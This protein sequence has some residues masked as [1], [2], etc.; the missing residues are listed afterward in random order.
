MKFLIHFLLALSLASCT[1][2]E[3]KVAVQA[4]SSFKQ[5]LLN[6]KAKAQSNPDQAIQ[7]I[8][9]TLSEYPEN[10]LSDDALFLLGQLLERKGNVEGA[11]KS[12]NR[13]LD[14]KYASPLDG[15]AILKLYDLYQKRNDTGK[16]LRVLNF[17]DR[18]ELVDSDSRLEIEKKRGPL[19]LETEDYIKYLE[20][21]ATSLKLS[22]DNSYKKTVFNKALA[23]MKIKILGTDNS[24]ILKNET[25][26]PFHPQAALH[27]AEYYFEKEERDKALAVL[28]ENS[29]ILLD[30]FY[31][32]QKIELIERAKA[33]ESANVNV[34]GVL[35]PLSG[36]YKS[37]GDKILKGLQFSLNIW[38]Q[39]NSDLPPIRL[40]ILDT[41][42]KPE[43]LELA[44]DEMIKKDRPV[45]FIGGLVGRTAEALI[46]KAEEFKTPA[47]ILSQKEGVAEGYKYSF[48][49][50]LPLPEYTN[51]ISKL[52]IE[53]LKFKKASVV[54]SEKLFS[55]MYAEA[56]IKSFTDMGG[57][58]VE[59]IAY[60]M[61]EKKSIPNAIKKLAHLDSANGRE[62]EYATAYNE[63]K[64][65]N[66][67]SRTKKDISIEDLL[68][69]KVE[70]DLLFI[71]DGPKNGG[72][73]ASTLAY[74]DI[75][76]LPLL[77]PHLWNDTSFLTRGQRFVEDSL[78]AD[79]YYEP[80]ILDSQCNKNFY[81]MYGQSLDTYNT[82][83]IE[84][85]L[86]LHLLLENRD[87]KSRSDLLYTLSKIT[88][89]K[90]PCFP[91]GL[92]REKSNFFAPLTPL[93]VKNKSIV[94]FD[95]KKY[96]K[97]KDESPE[98]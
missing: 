65:K 2:V 22:T 40:S 33:F 83:G 98:Y 37:V 94:I 55:K 4:P 85:G 48:Q 71:S 16:A 95:L 61:A 91:N 51:F 14:S 1:T 78:F 74:Y 62:A 75:D 10:D 96:S 8:N 43:L 29:N 27:L 97:L 36:R 79:S 19:L 53:E 20:S 56:F 32:N 77:G 63:W 28:E 46:A 57:E 26:K 49:I 70:S 93:T 24:L 54:H 59:V 38:K 12:Y 58:V 84:A 17:V 30:P 45:A 80:I 81:N 21:S 90:H 7:I 41:Q 42:A 6:A 9:Q 60:D 44:F 35:L 69:P 52:A 25:L 50:S 23:V 82:K 5:Q 89:F 31:E 67:N 87:I 64:K 11:L 86:I 66:N 18:A 34:I 3:K 72:L 76:D 39:K 68:T 92:V 15:K 73:I 13:I 88:F 47:L